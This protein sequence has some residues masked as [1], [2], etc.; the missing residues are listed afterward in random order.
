[1]SWS[2]LQQLCCHLM[3]PLSR[4]GGSGKGKERRPS[5][6]NEAHKLM[7]MY[8]IQSYIQPS[9]CVVGTANGKQSTEGKGGAG[10][11]GVQAVVPLSSANSLPYTECCLYDMDTSV[12]PGWP[13]TA[14]GLWLLQWKQDR[15]PQWTQELQSCCC[16]RCCCRE[17]PVWVSQNSPWGFCCGTAP[18]H[19][20]T[21]ESQLG[22]IGCYSYHQCR[23]GDIAATFK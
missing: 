20:Q 18:Q 10:S 12:S 1:M 4:G 11:G 17:F 23:L 9:K 7:L 13:E 6:W 5:G 3:T 16:S 22:P 14:E 19:I 8:F 2:E 15:C 21:S